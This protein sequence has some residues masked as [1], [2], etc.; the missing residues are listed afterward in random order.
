MKNSIHEFLKDIN[1]YETRYY[2]N[3]MRKRITRIL[4]VCTYYDAYIFEE[5]GKLSEQVSGEYNALNLTSAPLIKNVHSGKDALIELASND[6]DLVITS[7]RIGEITPFD[8][9]KEVKNK[10]PHIPIVLLL[11]VLSDISVIEKKNE[12]KEYIDEV[13]VW[14]GDSKIFLAIVKLFED[15]WNLEE[16]TENGLVRIILLIEDSI[17]YY[18]IFLPV[19]YA[20]IMKHIQQLI[21]S[22]L[23]DHQKL[24]RMRARPK[25]ILKHSYEDAYDF[26]TRYKKYVWSVISDVEFAMNGVINPKAGVKFISF[27]KKELPHLPCLL[28]SSE[29]SNKK[30][31]DALH[32][33]FIHKYS[34]ELLK[35]LRD[36]INYSL[37]F[38]DFIFHDQG[39]TFKAS[40]WMELEQTIKEISPQTLRYHAE[41]NHFSIWLSA[42]GEPQ[43]AMKMREKMIDDFYDVEEV[44][45]FLIEIIRF[46]RNRR[47]RGNVIEFNAS[48]LEYEDEI[49]R[50]GEGSFGGKGRG[51][52][53]MNH[54]MIRQGIN[55][56]LDSCKI[57]IPKTAIIGVRE[58]ELFL[59]ENQISSQIVE[60]D[61]D[62]IKDRFLK[63]ELSKPLMNKLEIY[64]KS[65]DKP[66]A[67]RSS[68]LL[69]DSQFQP[70]AG[71]YATYMLPNNSPDWETRLLYI[72]QAVKLV[73]AS[74]FLKN[75]QRYIE[76]L[77]YKFEE[78]KMAVII[79]Q[80]V[81]NRY[82]DLFYPH[83]SGVAQSHNYYS[84]NNMLPESGIVSLAF[85]LGITVVE[86]EKV[87]IFSPAEPNR[88]IVSVEHLL[89]HSQT[90]F[91]AIDMSHTIIDLSSGEAATLKKVDI[92]DALKHR[93]LDQV[94][95]TYEYEN[96]RLLPGIH[97]G[98]SK[99]INFANIL[100][101]NSF[102]LSQILKRIL[103]EGKKALGTPI[104][105]E[106]AVDLTK[107]ESVGFLPTFYLLQ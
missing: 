50:M 36:F 77:Q 34:K 64:A 75:A 95:S 87:F 85:G 86:G 29:L 83:F 100:K 55:N 14:N 26:F 24:L 63:G 67:V 106:F 53:F 81:G 2:Y 65:I 59:E 70:F 42:R 60:E 89:K 46:I 88:D 20:E 90:G 101:Y 97:S 93:T 92:Y 21:S 10:F 94:A 38:G 79:Q 56:F 15:S 37:G 82:E 69:E 6:Y 22:E 7:Y 45:R 54:F 66:I 48:D 12:I 99:V 105:I 47:N 73:F 91:Y 80:V 61:D 104:E 39:K 43:I 31:A 49:V 96:S 19:L 8:F 74:T 102:P 32:S 30:D 72:C 27:I 98:G 13:F 68:S 11:N 23:N 3:L 28:Q 41:N 103:D 9:A 84:T 52:T 44:R 4:L 18:S 17:H 62:L 78:E 57:R 107:D 1:N 71:V 33:G 35:C 5:D 76:S 25:V 58:F 51:L 16:D 40:N